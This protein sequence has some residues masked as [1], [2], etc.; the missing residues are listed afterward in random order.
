MNSLL[1]DLKYKPL[2][3]VQFAKVAHMHRGAVPAVC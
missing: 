2:F 3:A 1:M